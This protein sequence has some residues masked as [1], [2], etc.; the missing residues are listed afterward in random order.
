[1]AT[2]PGSL[3]QASLI[4]LLKQAIVDVSE[5]TNQHIKLFK[6]EIKH[7]VSRGIKYTSIA[8]AGALI[9]YTGVIFFGLFLIFALALILPLWAAALIVTGIYFVISIVSFILTKKWLD[10]LKAEQEYLFEKP[11][12]TLEET[13]KWLHDMK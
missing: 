5:L 6:A 7:E 9:T 1:M 8:V 2:E 3:K 11:K 4:T 12:E 10:E 13:Q